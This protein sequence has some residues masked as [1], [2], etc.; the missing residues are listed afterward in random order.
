Y[1]A[2]APS[3]VQPATGIPGWRPDRAVS[4]WTFSD[5]VLAASAD[6][7]SGW[8]GKGHP[9]AQTA[10]APCRR[11]WVAPVRPVFLSRHLVDQ[12]DWRFDKR[13]ARTHRTRHV[14]G[15]VVE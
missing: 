13:V 6:G 3:S 9:S 10:R 1:L 8:C 7:D 5:V 2:L 14:L 12:C 15:G 4:P 11:D